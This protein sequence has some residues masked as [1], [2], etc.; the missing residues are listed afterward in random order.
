[1]TAQQNR[2]TEYGS[3]VRRSSRLANPTENSSTPQ[4]RGLATP[5]TPNT[6]SVAAT[7]TKP[8]RGGLVSAEVPNSLAT[9]PSSGSEPERITPPAKRIT[10]RRSESKQLGST[11]IKSTEPINVFT[12]SPH[13]NKASPIKTS[14]PRSKQ[15][16]IVRHSSHKVSPQRTDESLAI[17]S[18][19]KIEPATLATPLKSE[20]K[21]PAYIKYANLFRDGALNDRALLTLPAHYDLVLRTFSALD[22]AI[23][24]LYGRSQRFIFHKSQEMVEQTTGRNFT[25][26]LFG[27]IFHLLPDAYNL[28]PVNIVK[29]GQRIKSIAISF[30]TNAAAP[31][32]IYT[33]E[34]LSIPN[35]I[36]IE[37]RRQNLR[38]VL[39]DIVKIEHEK[40]LA[41]IGVVIP[42]G[43]R[44]LNWHP[45]FNLEEIGP[46]PSKL[47]FETEKAKQADPLTVSDRVKDTFE[48][49]DE[50]ILKSTLST[51]KNKQPI[52]QNDDIGSSPTKKKKSL[53]DRIKEREAQTAIDIVTGKIERGKKIAMI[54]SLYDYVDTISL[55]FGSAKKTALTY[56]YL[57]EK[58]MDSCKSSTSSA[59]IREKFDMLL[60]ICP[61]WLFPLDEY[62]RVDKSKSAKELRS[63][64]DD[65]KRAI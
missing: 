54:E 22:T 39:T 11:T 43:K 13:Q 21:I 50:A 19:A 52:D 23:M 60:K 17:V 35:S 59:S 61:G 58:L 18:P 41:S 2:I 45:K 44:V 42:K 34:I 57:E 3:T 51:P 47:L 8:I 12:S 27:Q 38:N 48:I 40:F 4:K 56:R 53:L 25:L 30:K 9:V 36:E 62:Y 1:M 14:S 28:E 20:A 37:E 65:Y 7:K 24:L 6:T 64:L 16:E 29:N 15:T 46:I 49:R 32:G 63:L 26:E 5:G 31:H 10:A 55:A 33:D